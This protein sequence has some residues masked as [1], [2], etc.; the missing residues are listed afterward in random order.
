MHF[1]DKKMKDLAVPCFLYK[2]RYPKCQ[3]DQPEEI[4]Q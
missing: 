2:L 4:K 3:T 1:A